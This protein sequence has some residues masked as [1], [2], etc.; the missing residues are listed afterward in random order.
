RQAWL[1]RLDGD[2]GSDLGGIRGLV[3]DGSGVRGVRASYEVAKPKAKSSRV[4]AYTPA[5]LKKALKEL[6]LSGLEKSI[7]KKLKR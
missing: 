7:F 1:C 6:K 4:E 2:V 5:Q 3:Y